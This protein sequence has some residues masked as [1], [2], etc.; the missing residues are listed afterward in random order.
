MVD[1]E[2]LIKQREIGQ[3][4]IITRIVHDANDKAL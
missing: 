3:Q 1:K 2:E 4:I